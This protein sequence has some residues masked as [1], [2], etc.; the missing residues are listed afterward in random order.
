MQGRLVWFEREWES[1][2]PPT[3][4]T[5]DQHVLSSFS[6]HTT[7]AHSH[8]SHLMMIAEKN[9]Q[10]R[11]IFPIPIEISY[12]IEERTSEVAISDM[13]AYIEMYLILRMKSK[14]QI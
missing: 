14:S 10:F 2:N 8:T 11:L 7:H 13:A 4:H 9:S 1:P 6:F 3:R 12:E 5:Q